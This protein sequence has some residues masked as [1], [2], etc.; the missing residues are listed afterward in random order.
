LAWFAIA[1]E[2]RPINFCIERTVKVKETILLP[3]PLSSVGSDEENGREVYSPP[4]EHGGN[5]VT[6]D[7]WG[8]NSRL[9]EHEIPI[10]LQ[11]FEISLGKIVFEKELIAHL[12]PNQS[13]EIISKMDITKYNSKN[14][15]VSIAFTLPSGEILRSSADWPQPLKYIDF[16]D[17]KVTVSVDG[18]KVGL[19]AD[20][21]V[22]GVILDVE[23]DD[24]SGLEW[25]DNGFD[26]IPGEK[27][28]VTTKGL[29]GRKISISWYGKES[30]A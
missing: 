25:N 20:K 15:I 24:D 26:L 10:K 27:V 19:Q 5:T 30:S 22:K 23:G 28:Y 3:E 8:V 12:L 18:E 6:V 21:P 1:R 4:D 2:L 11:F 9:E 14:L 7:V 13:T 16:H 29:R 17:R